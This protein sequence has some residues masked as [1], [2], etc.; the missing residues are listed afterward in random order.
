MA[1]QQP[2]I[3]DTCALL[4]LVQGGGELSRE[5]LRSIGDA[6]AVYVSAI[7]G[8]EIGVK[9]KKGKL[10]LP[11]RPLEWFSTALEHHDISLVSL[12]LEVCI[13]ATELPA[14]HSDPCDRMIIATAQAHGLPVVTTDSVFSRYAVEV[15]A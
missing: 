9:V 13:R 1:G 7:S 6:A 14:I 10:Q 15:I 12:N 5:A 2:V 3:L 11:A 8:F 4:W